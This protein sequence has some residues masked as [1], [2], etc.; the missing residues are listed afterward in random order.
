MNISSPIRLFLTVACL[1]CVC[2]CASPTS[3]EER[4]AISVSALTADQ[5]QGCL[6]EETDCMSDFESNTYFDMETWARL[7]TEAREEC[8]K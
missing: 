6:N 1:A 8:E 4:E 7:C 3:T 5:E 2:S